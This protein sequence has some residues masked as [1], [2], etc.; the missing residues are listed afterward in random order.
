MVDYR[1]FPQAPQVRVLKIKIVAITSYDFQDMKG[2]DWHH[3]GEVSYEGDGEFSPDL[4]SRKSVEIIES[5]NSSSGWAGLALFSANPPPPKKVYFLAL[6][7]VK[8]I[9]DLSR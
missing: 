8:S 5:H 9:V 3:N 6:A 2:Y 7:Q 1:D 4:L